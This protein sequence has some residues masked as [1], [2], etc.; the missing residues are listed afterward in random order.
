MCTQ[1][2]CGVVGYL[3]QSPPM[4]RG[5]PHPLR[6][7]NPNYPLPRPP[8][9]HPWLANPTDNCGT[10][11]TGQLQQVGGWNPKP[12][13]LLSKRHCLASLVPFFE[14]SIMPHWEHNSA[15]LTTSNAPQLA[16]RHTSNGHLHRPKARSGPGSGLLLRLRLTAAVQRL[17]TCMPQRK[18]TPA[19]EGS[20]LWVVLT[21][22][23]R[24]TRASK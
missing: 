8:P 7:Q 1:Q 21:G 23:H 6:P 18:K 10:L 24:Q 20:A 4:T 15:P 5:S 13:P 9:T 17:W 11:S 16:H 14:T 12:P 22:R 2:C 19:Q 3:L